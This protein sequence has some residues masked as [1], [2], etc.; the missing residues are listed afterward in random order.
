MAV[1]FLPKRASV[2]LQPGS[3]KSNYVSAWRLTRGGGRWTIIWAND[4]L[5]T[6]ITLKSLCSLSVCPIIV[7]ECFYIQQIEGNIKQRAVYELNKLTCCISDRMETHE[8]LI[9]SP[10]NPSSSFQ[11][12]MRRK[13][14]VLNGG[15]TQFLL[16]INH[17]F[18]FWIQNTFSKYHFLFVYDV[19]GDWCL[20]SIG[21][22]SCW[23]C[24][25]KS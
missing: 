17:S 11:W 5:M 19:D 16:A 18:R 13:L 2:H 24:S 3:G 23:S 14:N 6:S 21:Q 1:I 12:A 20:Q 4:L 25:S 22:Y 15:K 7:Q 9:T 10:V 8:R